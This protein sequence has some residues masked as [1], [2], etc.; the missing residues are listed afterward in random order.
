M[1]CRSSS[2][3]GGVG[4]SLFRRQFACDV[5]VLLTCGGLVQSQFVDPL[6][7]GMTVV[8]W[9]SPS[10]HIGFGLAR[11]GDSP[12]MVSGKF[13]AA[14]QMVRCTVIPDHWLAW[15]GV[16]WSSWCAFVL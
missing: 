10:L 1:L 7:R 4:V 6:F 8:L 12:L 13:V 11:G 15:C 2:E 3:I 5:G 14:V 9:R 16:W